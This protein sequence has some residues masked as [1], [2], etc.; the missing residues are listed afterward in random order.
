MSATSERHLAGIAVAPGFAPRFPIETRASGQ[1][2]QLGRGPT[3]PRLAQAPGTAESGLDPAAEPDGRPGALHRAR[4]HRRVRH[5]KVSASVGHFVLAPEPLDQ[6]HGLVHPASPFVDGH[7]KGLKFLGRVADT[8]SQDQAASGDHVHHR[9]LLG[10]DQRMVQRE[11]EDG[12]AQANPPRPAGDGGQPDEWCRIERAVVVVLPEPHR[13]EPVGLGP[14]A[15]T[16]RLLEVAARLQRAQ[17][18]F[19]DPPLAARAAVAVSRWLRR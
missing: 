2:V 3:Q 9:R 13:L 18:E 12:G 8:H 6:W 19:H 14:L 4:A 15:L 7:A 11:Q 17:A 16:D 10:H 1:L 5:L